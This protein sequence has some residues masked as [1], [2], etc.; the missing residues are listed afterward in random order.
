MHPA[1]VKGAVA[2]VTGGA[3][4]I[5]L[6]AARR[7][8]ALGLRVCLVDQDEAVLARARETH[9]RRRRTG[10]RHRGFRKPMSATA[11]R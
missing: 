10:L 7:L 9:D 2:L 1:L 11:G 8:A 3:S 6:A 5:G 4:G